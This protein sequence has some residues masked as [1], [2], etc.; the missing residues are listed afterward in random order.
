V[1]ARARARAFA[2]AL[3]ARGLLAYAE[4]NVI[5][6]PLAVQQD[7]LSTTPYD[8]RSL[9]A[10]PSLDPPPVTSNS[11][12]IALIDAQADTGHE[13]FANDP[14]FSSLGTRPATI[15]HGTATASVAAAPA[16]GKGILGVWPG[17]RALNVPVPGDSITCS[18]SAN[19]IARAVAEGAAVINMSYGSTVECLTE[20]VAL[21]LAIGQGV[22]PVA[23]AGNDFEEGNPLEWPASEPHVLTVAATRRDGR[24][25]PF[26]SASAAVDLSAPGVDIRTAV[27]PAFS[28][29]G[30]PGYAVQSGTSFAAP[31]V[32]AA[33]AWVRQARPRLRADQVAQ[34][35][36]LSARDVESAGW[37]P[38]TGFGVLDVGAALAANVPP[39]DPNEPNDDMVW[40]DGTAFRY[41]DPPIW[42]GRGRTRLTAL[43]DG[44]E[45][46]ADVYRIVIPGRRRARVSADPGFGAVTLA[47]YRGN[48][49]GI[50]NTRRRLAIARRRG[51]ATQRL[52]VRNRARRRHVF[53]LVVAP[54]TSGGVLDADYVLRVR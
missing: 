45:D 34:A 43:L 20:R 13:E 1:V 25:A 28:D 14:N 9:V 40:V 12:L 6:R 42:S 10:K 29:A 15:A 23:A 7:P 53:Y 46:P 11:P 5:E 44:A 52:T 18:R 33:V 21:Y 24:S 37:D 2:A 39:H 48:A 30:T 47:A 8:W 17:A 41:P 31:M 36:R 3:R 51:G 35:I 38:D 16:N 22:T 50:S 4:P 19:S 49:L 26:S 54:Q 32:A 27:P